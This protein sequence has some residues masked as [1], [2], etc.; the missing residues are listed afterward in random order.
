MLALVII[1]CIVF[2][3]RPRKQIF[4]YPWKMVAGKMFVIRSIVRSAALLMTVLWSFD[5]KRV[6]GAVSVSSSDKHIMF[7]LDGSLSMSADDVS[8]NRFSVATDMIASLASSVND[9]TYS[10]AVFS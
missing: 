5:M 2:L 9:A 4:V 8:P 6:D 7:L 1:A 3:R 10:L